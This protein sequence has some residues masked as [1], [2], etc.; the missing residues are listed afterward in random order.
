MI[1]FNIGDKVT[2]LLDYQV[3][4]RHCDKII[5]EEGT[6]ACECEVVDTSYRGEQL[7]YCI[8]ILTNTEKFPF[9]TFWT[10]AEEFIKRIIKS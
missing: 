3:R 7:M 8:T 10:E 2:A 9:P 6:I 4:L 5:T 1:E